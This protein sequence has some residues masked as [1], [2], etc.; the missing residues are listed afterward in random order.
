MG[1]GVKRRGG[2]LIPAALIALGAAVTLPAPANA[3]I[4]CDFSSSVLTV[5]LTANDFPIIQRS[6]D[7][8][9]IRDNTAGQALVPCTGATPSVTTTERIE[10]DQTTAGQ[11]VQMVVDQSAGAFEPGTGGP[12]EGGG[13]P[14]IEFDIDLGDGFDSVQVNGRPDPEVD[15]MRFGELA[16]GNPG[17]NLNAPETGQSDG[18]DLELHD[19]DFISVFLGSPGDTANTLDGSGGPE[20]VDG[21]PLNFGGVGGGEGPDTLVGGDAGGTYDG[22]GGDDTLVSRPGSFSET[23]RGGTGTDVLDY[24]LATSGVTV[25]LGTGAGQD[26]G[27]AGFDILDMTDFEDLTGS[28]FGDDLT[29]T[30]GPNRIVGAEGSDTISLLDGD[31]Q[32]DVMDGEAD[33]VSCGAG[34]DDSGVADEQGVDTID[35]N[36]ETVDFPPQTSINAGPAD[37]AITNDRTPTYTLSADEPATFEYR[38]DGGSFQSC[39]Q[40][41]TVATLTEGAHTLDF[42]AT[43]QDAP[44]TA[45]PSPATRDVTVDVTPPQT[46]ITSGPGEGVTITDSTPTFGFGSETGA[47]FQCRIDGGA[48]AACISPRTVP[49]LSDGRHSF[50]VRAR[51]LAANLDPTPASRSFTVDTTAPQTAITKGPKRKVKTKKRRKKARFEFSS[52]DPD[53]T[54]ECALDAVAFSPCASPVLEKVKKGK[55][56]FEVRATD[57]AGNVEPQPATHTWKVKRKKR[58]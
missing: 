44:N 42:R 40:Q 25:N 27:G 51:D 50:Q 37:G 1:A 53:A 3:A 11:A 2:L 43:D 4:S 46:G 10:V 26:T 57:E 58:R 39:A 38:V 54:L 48:F 18:D 31:D 35:A 33:T 13:T 24:S 21:F 6:G 52:D 29:G 22:F 36:C 9:Q 32:F 5:N 19:V 28:G 15:H 49:A 30:D 34:T 20:F 7:E 14:E 45:D 12:A 41:C 23:L 56:E 55:H 17:V 8:I 16:S 47:S